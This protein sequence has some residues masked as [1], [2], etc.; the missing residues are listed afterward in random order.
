MPFEPLPPSF[1]KTLQSFS[2]F[3]APLP[4]QLHLLLHPHAHLD[5]HFLYPHPVK[6]EGGIGEILKSC[7]KMIST[8]NY[9]RL[10][11]NLV[12]PLFF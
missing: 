6:L 1:S 5:L 2:V 12:I 10:L 8:I 3:H 4:Q 9:F 7:L 11:Q